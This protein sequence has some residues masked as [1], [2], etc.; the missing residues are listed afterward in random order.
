M[1][2]DE[3]GVVVGEGKPLRELQGAERVR[4]YR[5]DV[6]GVVVYHPGEGPYKGGDL[7]GREG[8]LVLDVVLEGDVGA[9]LVF[10]C[11]GSLVAEAVVVVTYDHNGP[12]VVARL[13]R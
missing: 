8:G 10:P 6:V 11:D 2:P 3:L 1:C 12:G 5:G 7:D 9:A 4:G 13:L